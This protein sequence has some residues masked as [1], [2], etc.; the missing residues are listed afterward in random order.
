M[1]SKIEGFAHTFL[2]VMLVLIVYNVLVRSFVPT[3]VQGWIGI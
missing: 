3:T 2:T 1:E